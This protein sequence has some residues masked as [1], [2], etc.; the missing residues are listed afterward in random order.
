MKNFSG[1]ITGLLFLVILSLGCD[2]K[3]P[4]SDDF[5]YNIE[6]KSIL[7]LATA[8]V[9]ADG[10]VLRSSTTGEDGVVTFETLSE[11]AELSVKVCGGTTIFVSTTEPVAWNGCLTSKFTPT[12]E[13]EVI[14]IDILSSFID[15][16]ESETSSEEWMEYLSL[17]TDVF[18]EIKSSL[19]DAT[20]QYLWLQGFAVIAEN[21]SEANGVTPESQYSTEKLIDLIKEDLLDDNVI[22]GSTSSVFG[23]LNI[24]ASLMRSVIAEAVSKVSEEFNETD[25]KDWSETILKSEAKFLGGSGG[26]EDTEDPTYEIVSPEPLSYWSNTAFEIHASDEKDIKYINCTVENV[27]GGSKAVDVVNTRDDIDEFFAMS[28]DYELLDGLVRLSCD[29]SDGTNIVEM[30]V[31]S[32][33][34]TLHP[35]ITIDLE[36]QTYVTEYSV[37]KYVVEELN[38]SSTSFA[39]KKGSEEPEDS[40][41][42]KT[43]TPLE[44]DIT[45]TKDMID[46]DGGYTVYVSSDDLAKNGATAQRSIIFDTQL[47]ETEIILD[48]VINEL[49]FISKNS[50]SVRLLAS[51]NVTEEG[52]LVFESLIDSAWTKNEDDEN[53]LWV[54]TNLEDK[55][56]EYK[57]RIKDQAGNIKDDIIVSFTV[58]TVD[59]EISVNKGD[60]ESRA[61]RSDDATFTLL[62][63]CNDVNV[64]SFSYSINQ[65]EPVEIETSSISLTNNTALVEGGNSLKLYCIDKAGNS[66]DVDIAIVIDN[67]P[68]I[69]SFI[70]MPD[71]SAPLCVIN[72]TLTVSGVDD[73]P[74]IEVLNWYNLD[75]GSNS[76][77][78]SY[79]LNESNQTDVY[80]PNSEDSIFSNYELYRNKISSVS[81]FFTLE[82]VAGNVS[83]PISTGWQIDG[84]PPKG[85]VVYVNDY[86][87][88][89]TPPNATQFTDQDLEDLGLET[90]EEIATYIYNQFDDI[91]KVY[92]YEN[93]T[94]INFHEHINFFGNFDDDPNKCTV[95]I[96]SV[97]GEH[98][99]PVIYCGFDPSSSEFTAKVV[100]EDN[101]GNKGQI[102]N[103]KDSSY[104]CVER[105]TNTNSPP[106][107]ISTYQKDA[108]TIVLNIAAEGANITYCHIKGPGKDFDCASQKGDQFFNISDWQEG[109][110]VATVHSK[111]DSGTSETNA[112]DD[113]IVDRTPF[114]ASFNLVNSGD[115]ILNSSPSFT[116]NINVASG[117]K[118]AKFYVRGRTV[119]YRHIPEGEESSYSCNTT[120][121]FCSNSAY[122]KLIYTTSSESGTF[123]ASEMIGGIYSKIYYEVTPNFGETIRQEYSLAR[124]INLI[125]STVEDSRMIFFMGAIHFTE[126]IISEKVVTSDFVAYNT[127]PYDSVCSVNGSY[128][129]GDNDENSVPSKMTVDHNS[130]FSTI[131]F[132]PSEA[133]YKFVNGGC[134]SM[135]DCP[136]SAS[137]C[138]PFLKG[139]SSSVCM[140]STAHHYSEGLYE[141]G[142]SCEDWETP[143]NYG[144]FNVPLYYAHCPFYRDLSYYPDGL[145]VRVN[146]T[147][148]PRTYYMRDFVSTHEQSECF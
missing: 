78:F 49:G 119:N 66:S 126:S 70:N 67:T 99:Y 64:N 127:A 1:V 137:S 29:I 138:Q 116:Y 18:P 108:S 141:G 62:S 6:V 146:D 5:T 16:Y 147:V 46:E 68:P 77:F 103:C 117:L 2:S 37:I 89:F 113:F 25:L 32:T 41:W 95:Y 88:G 11:V 81:F 104:Y 125:K 4:E 10:K 91:A 143:S 17:T 75:L 122:Q 15:T 47:P 12:K 65:G 35:S 39:I 14:V 97:D 145:R 86:M 83:D 33:K 131:S 101:C 107:H 133:Q 134:D 58:D 21:I 38:P 44:G 63:F 74:I 51:D 20:K 8:T 112:T 45:L 79:E 129:Y 110:F 115:Y 124:D 31:D 102:T 48:P 42:I 144:N 54:Y 30:F 72:N 28:N 69:P 139:S 85:G 52:F 136:L 60:L 142:Y 130:G 135:S 92:F 13:N 84:E 22:N 56:Y 73:N 96:Y 43:S 23:T 148:R 140:G 40:D 59:P 100:F 53:N 34:D 50:L 71:N 26:E 121:G 90:G 55:L 114:S 120:A 93:D 128:F 132:T 7:S 87:I 36:G 19:T 94:L 57:Y 27:G 98:Y 24:N 80:Y 123:S 118:E 105:F 3:R 9:E 82:D 111:Y 76:S 109:D 106:L 61:Y